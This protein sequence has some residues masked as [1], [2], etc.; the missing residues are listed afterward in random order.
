MSEVKGRMQSFA[1]LGE[2]CCNKPPSPEVNSTDESFRL[3]GDVPY[4]S[5]GVSTI[6]YGVVG[7][8][9]DLKSIMFVFKNSNF[10]CFKVCRTRAFSENE[11]LCSSSAFEI[12]SYVLVV[13][14]S[15][16]FCT[17]RLGFAPNLMTDLCIFRRVM[18][19]LDAGVPNCDSRGS[20]GKGGL[21]TA[22]LRLR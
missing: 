2:T 12:I 6:E 20:D 7:N 1:L 17:L 3:P 8:P 11:S 9:L 5:L 22:I 19:D 16:T 13:G 10:L 4:S 15:G 18:I 21:I 14:G